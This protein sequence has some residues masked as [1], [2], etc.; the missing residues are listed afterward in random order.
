MTP[1]TL[2]IEQTGAKDLGPCDCCGNLTRRVWGLAHR[3]EATEAA[4]FVEWTAGAVARHGAQFDLVIGRWGDGA[5]SAD[6]VAVS[7]AFRHTSAGPQFMVVDASERSTAVSGVVGRALN[8]CDVLNTPL[9]T[10]AFAIVDAIWLQD[11]RL[12]EVTKDA[13]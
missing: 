1:E 9:A 5:T 13:A 8:G 10:Q 11:D 7:L 6:R 3:G 2:E 12:A 4:Y